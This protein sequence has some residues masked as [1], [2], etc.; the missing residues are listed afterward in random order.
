MRAVSIRPAPSPILG[1]G[2]QASWAVMPPQ[3]TVEVTR[4][5]PCGLLVGAWQTAKSMPVASY[6]SQSPLGAS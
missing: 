3:D 2:T 1:S 4:S 5:G 6:A